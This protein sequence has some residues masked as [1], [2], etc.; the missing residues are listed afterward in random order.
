MSIK[1]DVALL[2][3]AIEQKLPQP[4]SEW[5]GGYP[6]QIE[7]ALLDAVL[8]VRAAYGKP[9]NGVRGA[10]SRYRARV[11]KGCDDLT[12]L[13]RHDPHELSR[14]LENNQKASG[15]SK[16]ELIVQ[17]ASNLVAAGV[18]RAADLDVD[19]HRRAYTSVHGL[20]K[21]TWEY[22][23]MLLGKPGVKAD[24]WV[25]RWISEQVGRPLTSDEAAALVREVA[26]GFDDAPD[27]ASPLL[28]RLDHQIW[29]TARGRSRN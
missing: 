25:T 29:L 10:T 26:G 15:R 23:T 16:S 21:V 19:E 13:A 24:T 2:H 22:F 1:N 3:R 9:H 11:G 4:W 27:A 6:D 7:A 8:S 12:R 20:G 5:P 14:I 18:H 28:T 17:A